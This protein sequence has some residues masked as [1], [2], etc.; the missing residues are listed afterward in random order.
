MARKIRLKDV[1]E[2]QGYDSVEE[3]LIE[4]GTDSV[5]PACCSEGC[6]V[7]PDGKCPHGNPSILLEAGMI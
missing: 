2:E 1:A 6:Q 4:L 7:E 3:M 5:M